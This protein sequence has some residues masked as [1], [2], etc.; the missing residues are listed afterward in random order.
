MAPDCR[1]TLLDLSSKLD[2]ALFPERPDVAGK[3]LQRRLQ[4]MRQI[5]G[6][7]AGTGQR[8]FL[9]LKQTVDLIGKRLHFAGRDHVETRA[10]PCDHVAHCVAKAFQ[11]S[12]SDCDLDEDR[13][14]EDE[15]QQ[16]ERWGELT[17]VF[18]NRLL[19]GPVILRHRRAK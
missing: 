10:A 8:L 6:T 3:H 4:T 16:Q 7:G 18:V 15:R 2:L 13:A 12:Q 17:D 11:R 19:D 14:D 9:R 1:G 5:G